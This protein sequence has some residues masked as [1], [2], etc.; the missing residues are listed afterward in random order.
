M[1]RTILLK[2]DS[3]VLSGGSILYGIQL[4][5]HPTITRI[6]SLSID[7]RDI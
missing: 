4:L 3:L 5:M 6:Q 2:W 7:T 1:W